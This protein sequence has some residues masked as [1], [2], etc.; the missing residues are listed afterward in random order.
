MY[1]SVF[2]IH[3]IF[4]LYIN[5]YVVFRQHPFFP[6]HQRPD[7]RISFAFLSDPGP[8]IVYPSQWLTDSLTDS[9]TDWLTD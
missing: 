8:I 7:N 5:N 3:Q 2:E 6:Q 9:L 4:Q 1:T